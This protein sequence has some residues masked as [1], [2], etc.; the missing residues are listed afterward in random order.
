M[1]RRNPRRLRRPETP[2][3]HL[4]ASRLAP[5]ALAGDLV[6]KGISGTR[7]EERRVGRSGNMKESGGVGCGYDGMCQIGVCVTR[8]VT[9]P[10]C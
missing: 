3:Q 1:F 10:P 6:W 5:G 7:T 2:K 9:V 4:Q 8:D